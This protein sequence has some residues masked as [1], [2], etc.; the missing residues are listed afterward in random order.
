MLKE[1]DP[2]TQLLFIDEIREKL[3]LNTVLEMAQVPRSTYYYR[4]RAQKRPDKYELLKK[5]IFTIFEEHNGWYGYRRITAQLH[6]EKVK[7][8]HKLVL[9]LMQQM[10]LSGKVMKKKYNSF[11]GEIGKTAPDLLQRDFHADAPFQ[12]WTTDITEFKIPAG[13]VY[14]SPIMDL[15]NGE[16]IAYDVA[17]RAN[18]NQV[19]RML[20]RAFRILPKSTDLILHSDQG[21]QYRDER[22]QAE[23]KK[24]HIRQSMSRKGNCLDN[25]A[26]ENFFGIM[27][28]EMFIGKEDTYSSKD[29]LIFAIKAWIFYYNH[30]RIKIKHRMAPVRFKALTE[31]QKNPEREAVFASLPGDVI[32]YNE[33]N[34]ESLQSLGAVH[35]IG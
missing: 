27:K 34:G 13:K 18:L 6:A 2:V 10:G 14:L 1:L 4:K 28:K 3:P 31:A 9:R 8:N 29:E 30:H 17:L 16:I 5:R 26:M 24:H 33:R 11:K 32:S 22:Y 12:K 21:W 23:L 7:V 20:H 35:A 15:F 25:A 19:I